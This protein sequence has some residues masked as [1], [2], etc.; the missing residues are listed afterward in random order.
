[1]KL[2]PRRHGLPQLLDSAVSDPIFNRSRCISDYFIHQRT[3]WSGTTG[4]SPVTH[5]VRHVQYTYCLVLYTVCIGIIGRIFWERLDFR[6]YRT[7]EIFSLTWQNSK[8]FFTHHV[9]VWIRDYFN[10][11]QNHSIEHQNLKNINQITKISYIFMS[12]KF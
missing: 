1:M 2:T 9:C 3:A 4:G 7:N 10:I 12:F 5:S 11:S 8:K 6:T